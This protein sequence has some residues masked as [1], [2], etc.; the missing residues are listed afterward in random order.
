[1]AER[2]I[3]LAKRG[4]LANQRLAA[5][6]VRNK[7]VLAKVFG[8][9]KKRYEA[10]AGGYTR[11]IRLGHRQGDAAEMVLLELVDRPAAA[12]EPK[13]DAPKA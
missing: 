9:L 11:M 3:T 4:G 6:T 1:V 10:R 2:I 12:T 7:D 13:A 8:D 5:R